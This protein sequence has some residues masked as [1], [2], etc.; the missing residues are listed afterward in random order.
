M[1]G[2]TAVGARRQLFLRLVFMITYTRRIL[3][4]RRG[5]YIVEGM[6]VCLHPVLHTS[7]ERADPGVCW[8]VRRQ[9]QIPLAWEGWVAQPVDRSQAFTGRVPSSGHLGGTALL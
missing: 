2:G 5:S 9:S 6:W 1:H 3:V 7:A 8:Y 4:P